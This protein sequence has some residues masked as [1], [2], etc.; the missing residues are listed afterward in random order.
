MGGPYRVSQLSS[1]YPTR[2]DHVGE[3]QIEGNGPGIVPA[4]NVQ[5]LGTAFGRGDVLAKTNQ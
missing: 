3:Q 2:H 4:E 1:V 5:R